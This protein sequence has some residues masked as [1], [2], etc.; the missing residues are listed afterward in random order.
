M[1]CGNKNWREKKR[2][3]TTEGKGERS[4]SPQSPLVFSLVFPAYDLT[5]S[6]PSELCALLYERLKEDILHAIYNQE[7]SRPGINGTTSHNLNLTYVSALNEIVSRCYKYCEHQ[8]K[9]DDVLATLTVWKITSRGIFFRS[10]FII[11][12]IP[13]LKRSPS[14]LFAAVL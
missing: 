2:G 10:T 8:T 3:E 4:L 13:R 7:K 9:T 14:S 6:L 5:R 1:E 12:L 11:C